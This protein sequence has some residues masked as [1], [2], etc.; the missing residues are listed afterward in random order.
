MQSSTP[1]GSVGF[2]NNSGLLCPRE[3]SVFP[4][5][6]IQTMSNS[7]EI[8]IF[9]LK[10]THQ[11]LNFPLSNFRSPLYAHIS[12][13]PP[14]HW[15]ILTTVDYFHLNFIQSFNLVVSKDTCKNGSHIVE[16]NRLSQTV[17]LIV[18]VV[19]STSLIVLARSRLGS[20]EDP[21]S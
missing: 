19:C 18:N 20:L 2:S 16:A 5:N 17:S 8:G 3:W 12:K 15:I 14:L 9:S 13:F 7:T 11:N 21:T 4:K 6:V 10:I 1:I